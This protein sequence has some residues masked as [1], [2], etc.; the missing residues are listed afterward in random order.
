MRF[1]VS[2]QKKRVLSALLCGSMMISTG[3]PVFAFADTDTV[4]SSVFSAEQEME[5]E[6]AV[7]LSVSGYALQRLGLIAGDDKGDLMLEKTGTRQEAFTIFLSLLG[8]KDD[9]NAVSYSYG[10]GD[11][12][13][14]FGNYA[15]YGLYEHYTAGCSEKKFGSQD[16]VTPEQYMTFALKALGY[17]DSDFTWTESLEKAVAIGL[18]T[19]QQADSWKANAFRRQEIM[20]ISYLTLSAKLKNSNC[21]L[22]D[23]LIADGAITAEAAENEGLTFGETYTGKQDWDSK[24][25]IDHASLTAGIY[26]LHNVGSGKVMT[27]AVS[28]QA[29]VT[30]GADQDASTQKFKIVNN[31]DGSFHIAS[32]SNTS[33]MVDVNPTDGADALLWAEN[34]TTCQNY[35]AVEM[36]S[37]AYSIRLENNTNMAL[38]AV[39]GDVRLSAYDGSDNQKWKLSTNQEDTAAAS[40]KLQSIMTVYPNGKNLGSSYSFGGASQCMAFGREVFYRMFG[41]VAK[42]NYDG[43]PKSSSDGALYKIA[44]KTSSYSASSVKSLISKAKPGDILQMDSPKIHTMVYVS[45]DSEGFTVYDAN[46]TASNQVSVRYVK[47]GAWSSRNSNGLSL[48]H[49]TKYPKS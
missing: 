32:A 29:D 9:A 43:S 44:A 34:G 21:T 10:F 13:S 45:R 37:G 42:W 31:S 6:E 40:A 27:S 3:V 8:E 5:Q 24:K 25:T 49:S 20:E 35:V 7:D 33:L 4:F 23:K 16:A 30:L 18:C 17:T 22:A 19:Q 2:K 28:K 39:N 11:V 38:T 36:S 41:S 46:W 26:E 14:W 15:G 48:L 47:Y 1:D 12:A